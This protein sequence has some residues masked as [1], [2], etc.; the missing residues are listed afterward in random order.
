MT[1]KKFFN[2][3]SITLITT[4]LLSGSAFA[5]TPSNKKASDAMWR[6]VEGCFHLSSEYKRDSNSYEEF[7]NKSLWRLNWVNNKRQT[8]AYATIDAK[9]QIISN[10]N[11]NDNYSYGYK[12]KLPTVSKEMARK[13]A[14]EAVNKLDP[15]KLKNSKLSSGTNSDF[16]DYYT[17][18]WTRIAYGIPFPEN[19]ITIAVD[20]QTGK[21]SS[22]SSNWNY[23]ATFPIPDIK[24]TALQARQTLLHS[25]NLRL[26]FADEWKAGGKNTY[27]AYFMPTNYYN[28]Y[29]NALNSKIMNTETF[30]SNKI[31]SSVYKQVYWKPLFDTAP[32][33]SKEVILAKVYPYIPF[34][35]GYKLNRVSSYGDPNNG[36][37]WSVDYTK[38]DT[39][40]YA[41]IS[42][43]FSALG[44]LSSYNNNRMWPQKATYT[45]QEC[46]K[47][48]LAYLGNYYN[49][50]DKENLYL[51]NEKSSQKQ[52]VQNFTFIKKFKGYPY[53]GQSINICINAE[54]LSLLNIYI[55]MPK[56]I[57]KLPTKLK[58][59]WMVLKDVIPEKGMRLQ[60]RSQQK[61]GVP[62]QIM[63][64]Y[65][66]Q[67][68]NNGPVSAA[69]NPPVQA[70]TPPKKEKILHI[71][72]DVK[73]SSSEKLINNLTNRGIIRSLPG[74]LFKPNSYITKAD[75]VDM[76]VRM[77]VANG[78]IN[79]YNF[80]IKKKVFRDV[81]INNW[82]YVPAY[83]AY[84]NNLLPNNVSFHPQ[85][86]ITKKEMAFILARA[87]GYSKVKATDE[88]FNLTYE[89]HQSMR[90][91][92][93]LEAA[94]IFSRIL[95]Q[96]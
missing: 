72:E 25:L 76:V 48:A 43:T 32:I 46:Q 26:E 12:V 55:N 2:L 87:L 9:T 18:T 41:N 77:Q 30:S 19:Y 44:N 59:P 21:I 4:V 69:L 42:Y 17:F 65:L 20:G 36:K 71:Y 14:E 78:K 96:K 16:A 8:S 33:I 45:R 83:L 68:K 70:K 7:N 60:Y 95:N 90:H 29:V 1:I 35:E 13:T 3:L 40:G 73:N 53:N 15:Y 10:F 94:K 31:L 22:Y 79:A 80:K 81:S 54:N 49:L 67:W 24:T 86:K 64:I 34:D 74:S 58:E 39:Q 27:L 89:V 52:P 84:Q 5:K 50:A 92:T 91:Y 11:R 82:Y 62:T 57:F 85:A 66:P 51:V 61:K 75:F 6:A 23:N 37:T 93:R 63:L 28:L 38:T 56:T 88:L 47:K